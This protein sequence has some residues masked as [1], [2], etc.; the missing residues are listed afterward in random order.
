MELITKA[1]K[2]T[3]DVLPGQSEKWLVIEKVLR[4]EA[5]LYGFS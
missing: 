2:G 4:D 1:P 3:Q 5:A